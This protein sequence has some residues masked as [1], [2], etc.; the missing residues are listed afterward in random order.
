MDDNPNNNVSFKSRLWLANNQTGGSLLRWSYDVWMSIIPHNYIHLFWWT[1]F[2]P[3]LTCSAN[4]GVVPTS[5]REVRV[6]AGH[7]NSILFL[8]MI[9]LFG[10]VLQIPHVLL[11]T[12][13]HFLNMAVTIC[14]PHIYTLLY[15]KFTFSNKCFSL[16]P[17]QV[18]VKS[19]QIFLM[20]TNQ[21]VKAS[22]IL[23]L[24]RWVHWHSSGSVL[25]CPARN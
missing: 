19:S 9:L 11:M 12:N 2:L 15:R 13:Y 20:A 23:C 10:E 24:S 16:D 5:C 6:S 22:V 4:A 14:Q 3:M 18:Y 7:V 25:W 1:P 8:Q 17:D 21:A